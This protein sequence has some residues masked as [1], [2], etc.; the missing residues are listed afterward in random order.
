[1]NAIYQSLKFQFN[2]QKD[3]QGYIDQLNKR[4]H[5]KLF[6]IENEKNTVTVNIIAED[7]EQSIEFI[8]VSFAKQYN[9]TQIK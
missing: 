9:G 7:G 5:K 2:N 8:L 4:E 3:A 1:M 6:Y